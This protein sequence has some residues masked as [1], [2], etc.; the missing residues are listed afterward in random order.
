MALLEKPDS[1][2]DQYFGLTPSLHSNLDYEETYSDG[3]TSSEAL[4]TSYED[5][6]TIRL[7]AESRGLKSIGDLGSGI[8]RICFLFNELK[9][10]VE[11]YGHE[12]VKER[13][14]NSQKAFQNH[15]KTEPL[16]IIKTNLRIDSLPHYESYFLYLPVGKTL[17]KIISQ[18]KVRTEEEVILYVIESHGDL[19]SFLKEM[20]PEI[21]LL[22]TYP[23]SKKRHNPEL[24]VFSLKRTSSHQKE[25]K[26]FL[27]D[28]LTELKNNHEVLFKSR[29]IFS[30]LI[31]LF[32]YL[33]ERFPNTQLLIEDG[34]S[35]KIWVG[36]LCHFENGAREAT[37][38]LKHPPRTISVENILGIHKPQEILI[39]LIEK[40]RDQTVN[41]LPR[42]I[43]LHPE[44]LIEYSDGS[45]KP[46]P[47]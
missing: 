43:F 6:N 44:K 19:L 45:F 8:S 10:S 34:E 5:L 9:S 22:K 28:S 40:R 17:R 1:E 21:V 14:Q 23:L 3:L 13:V 36:D 12:V 20:F 35:Q 38:E 26:T 2:I 27:E 39:K 46:F 15:F 31:S 11:A 37:L 32:D 25:E 41:P 7:D 47:E 4:Y 30:H 29:P 18:L 16:S 24:H 33:E 42:K